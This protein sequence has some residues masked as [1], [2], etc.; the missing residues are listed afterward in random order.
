MASDKFSKLKKAAEERKAQKSGKSGPA[1]KT[2]EPKPR[3]EPK[4]TPPKQKAEAKPEP[5]KRA[6]PSQKKQA[7]AEPPPQKKSLQPPQQKRVSQPPPPASKKPKTGEEPPKAEA[8]KPPEVPIFRQIIEAVK[9][10]PRVKDIELAARV[11][12]AAR[13]RQGEIEGKSKS[14]KQVVDEEVARL[15]PTMPKPLF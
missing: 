2:P 13:G 9:A 8:A 4:A 14:V 15:L 6:E 7:P 3:V 10:D 1:T 5:A 12:S 11:V